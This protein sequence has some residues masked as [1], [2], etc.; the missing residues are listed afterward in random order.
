LQRSRAQLADTIRDKV[1]QALVKFDES[2]TEFQ[3][4]QILTA[5]SLQQFQ[6]YEIRY[7]RGNSETETYLSR[8]NQLDNNNLNMLQYGCLSVSDFGSY[9][10]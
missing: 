7:T 5:R 4:S 10:F 3:T 6:V 8:Q 2:R 9:F 1:A